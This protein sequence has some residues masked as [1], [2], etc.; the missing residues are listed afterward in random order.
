M[1]GFNLA[2][3]GGGLMQGASA[4]M[5]IGG[6]WGA[7]AGGLLGLGLGGFGGGDTVD[8]LEYG[9]TP[10]EE[11][12]QKYAFD[13]TKASPGQ[14]RKIVN[15]AKSYLKNKGAGRGAFESYLEG[16][17]GRYTNPEFIDKRLARSYDKPI[18]YY[19]KNYRATAKG[20]FDTQG[21]GFTPEEY[22][23]FVDQAKAQK[24]RSAAAF[25]DLLKSNMIASGKV[26]SPNQQMLADIFGTPERDASGR[27]TGRY[28][29][30]SNSIL[31]KAVAKYV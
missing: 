22:D 23:S 16:L 15:K 6:P 8:P 11:E 29:D 18:N 14:K 26:M 31:S 21:I 1:S 28:G 7:A 27:L 25:G 17:E 9:L 10:R 12:L 3:A 13:Q 19:R 2:G 30:I 24:V 20:L 5:A 4:G